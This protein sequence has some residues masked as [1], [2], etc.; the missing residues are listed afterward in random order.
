MFAFPFQ[1]IVSMHRLVPGLWDQTFGEGINEDGNGSSL[2]LAL[3]AE[4]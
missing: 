4:T 1:Y 3:G 2:I